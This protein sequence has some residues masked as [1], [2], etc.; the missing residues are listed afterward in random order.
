VIHIV[1][2][3]RPGDTQACT[4]PEACSTHITMVSV[5]SPAMLYLELLQHCAEIVV[6][7]VGF[8]GLEANDVSRH[9]RM[10]ERTSAIGIVM[11]LPVN[12]RRQRIAALQSGADVLLP[13]PV[14]ADEL[15]ASLHGLHRRLAH[16]NVDPEPLPWKFLDSEWRLITPCGRQIELSRLEAAFVGI[17]ARNAGRPVPRRD[18][19]AEAFG[20]DPA[21][22]D[23]R[24]LE[25]IVS[26][27]RRKLQDVYSVSQPIKVVHSVGY[28][29]TD[30]IRCVGA[31]SV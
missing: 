6:L 10:V 15:M 16:G 7:D 4:L 25:A 11:L 12:E 17:V 18:I 21:A 2:L 1:V 23:N 28:V 30:P 20:Q 31:V 3:E 27:L 26:R 8:L 19:I 14:H 22:Y 13:K 5:G 9:L 24:R 29:F